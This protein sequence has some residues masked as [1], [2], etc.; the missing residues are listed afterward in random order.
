MG[1]LRRCLAASR[2]APH[3]GTAKELKPPIRETEP[4]LFKGWNWQLLL[5]GIFSGAF[6]G[7]ANPKR[8]CPSNTPLEGRPACVGVAARGAPLQKPLHPGR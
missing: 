3:R 1:E 2:A 4:L 7:W 8:I 6:L 5:S